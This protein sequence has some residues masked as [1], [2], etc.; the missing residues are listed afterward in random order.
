MM[1][2]VIVILDPQ[3]KRF[4]ADEF[5]WTFIVRFTL[6]CIILRCHSSFKEE[7]VKDDHVVVSF[8]SLSFKTYPTSSP[9]LPDSIYNAEEII[10][11]LHRLTSVAKVGTYFNLPFATDDPAE[12]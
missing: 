7:K 9:A 10:T 5:L 11:M 6:C 1:T 4:M 12:P 2:H 3:M 8:D